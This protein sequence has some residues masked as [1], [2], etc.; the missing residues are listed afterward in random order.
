MPPRQHATEDATGVEQTLCGRPTRSVPV[1]N[2][3]VSC[4]ACLKVIASRCYEHNVRACRV[5]PR[6]QRCNGATSP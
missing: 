5:C 1:N 4:R 2:A 3:A 6:D